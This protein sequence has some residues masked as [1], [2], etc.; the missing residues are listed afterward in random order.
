MA[1]VAA[2]I[3]MALVDRLRLAAQLF[4]IP[5]RARERRGRS[6]ARVR[7]ARHSL[8]RDRAAVTYHY[9]TQAWRTLR[10]GG[11]F[12]NHAIGWN[13]MHR[14]DRGPSFVG[15]Y[16]FPDGELLPISAIL[17]AAETCGFEVRDVESLREHYALTLRHWVRRLEAQRAAAADATDETT[18]RVWRA[19]M[20]GSAH[21]FETGRLNVYQALLVKQDRGRSRL[22]LTREDWYRQ[23]T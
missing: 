4:R 14:R 8:D 23:A 18:Y 11:V 5:A 19:Y 16:V 1:E 9:N 6:A 12:L 17:R 3:A 15:R 2:P 10:P 13:P 22:P 20:A 7:G 21:G